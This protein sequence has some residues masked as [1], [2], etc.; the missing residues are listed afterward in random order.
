MMKMASNSIASEIRSSEQ[1]FLVSPIC[2]LDSFH[3]NERLK[4]SNSFFFYNSF[5]D[6][7]YTSFSSSFF[8]LHRLRVAI[9]PHIETIANTKE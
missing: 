3:A 9:H 8:S 4:G 7:L 1:R 5:S 2:N 6:S